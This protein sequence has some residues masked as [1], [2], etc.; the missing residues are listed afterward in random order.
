[1]FCR[2]LWSALV[3]KALS[4]SVSYTAMSLRLNAIW[5][6]AGGNQVTSMKKGYFLIRF[7]SSLAYERAI[8][9]G[10]WMIGS[11][12]LTVHMWDKYFDPYEHEISST[13][14]WARLLELP[15]HYFHQD[16]VMKIGCR[17]GKPIRIDA[18]TRTKARSDYARV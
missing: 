2:D 10:P 17:M 3:V 16:A 18:A 8:T 11:S 14:V 12:Y 9:D 7:T 6:K 4:R 1:M 13:V 15:I 5:A